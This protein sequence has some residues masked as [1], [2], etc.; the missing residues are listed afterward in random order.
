VWHR[1]ADPYSN[2][3]P[4][5]VNV[6]AEG[7][8][9]SILAGILC[10]FAFTAIVLLLVTWLADSRPA[11]L[12]LMTA[13]HALLASFFGLLIMCLLYAAE[14]ANSTSWGLAISENTVLS[15]GF[16]GTG[17][18]V[19]YAIVV[20]LDA[21]AA[22]T[23]PPAAGVRRLA[24]YSRSFACVAN[25]LLIGMSYDAISDYVNIRHGGYGSGINSI[26]VVSWISV[27]IQVLLTVGAAW[28]IV[29]HPRAGRF[30]DDRHSA[31]WLIPTVGLG[32]SVLAAVGYVAT[33]VALPSETAMIAPPWIMMIQLVALTVTAGSTVYL[34]LTRPQ[35]FPV[36]PET[37]EALSVLTL[38]PG[39]ANPDG[40]EP[41]SDLTSDS[42]IIRL[43]I[44]IEHLLRSWHGFGDRH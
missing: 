2:P 33:D 5:N 20:M 16:I 11:R 38:L 21:A 19:I 7:T 40:A 37:P 9:Y 3:F 39:Q 32:L 22:T 12:V 36:E 8:A 17:I 23:T 13:G 44:H 30:A 34:A 14:S 18:T 1:A 43:A 35:R 31:A 26:D 29:R 25:L 10:G 28:V 4:V 15:D 27:G 41:D 24:L 42:T 6:A